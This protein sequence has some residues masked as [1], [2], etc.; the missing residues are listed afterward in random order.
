MIRGGC[1][2]NRFVRTDAGIAR[3]G[4]TPVQRR[5]PGQRRARVLVQLIA[6]VGLV[7]SLAVAATAVSIG[8]ARAPTP[9]AVTLLG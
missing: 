2:V 4:F 1:V 6:T 7:A 9:N 8:L 5:R 3:T